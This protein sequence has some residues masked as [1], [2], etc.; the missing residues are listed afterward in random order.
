MVILIILGIV[1]FFAGVI[2]LLGEKKI[3]SVS[4]VLN[5]SF[6]K[7]IFNSDEFFLKNRVGTGVSLVLLSVLFFFIAYWLSVKAQD[8]LFKLIFG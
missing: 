8:N 4:S 2:F 7:I 3:N 1:T 5:V 6:N